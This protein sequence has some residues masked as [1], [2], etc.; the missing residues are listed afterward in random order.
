MT[1]HRKLVC[2]LSA[3]TIAANTVTKF[4][5]RD[6][7][8][9]KLAIKFKRWIIAY[10]NSYKHNKYGMFHSRKKETNLH[11]FHWKLSINSTEKQT[12]FPNF[13]ERNKTV[14]GAY[15]SA[16]SPQLVIW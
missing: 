2:Q 4:T 16:A 13:H 12:K 3:H 10:F 15:G 5:L 8:L 6:A 11:T 7:I 1:D 14:T 9:N